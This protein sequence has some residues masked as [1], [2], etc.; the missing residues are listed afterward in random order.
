[1]RFVDGSVVEDLR[2]RVPCRDPAESIDFSFQI[3]AGAA[4]VPLQVAVGDPER[5]ASELVAPHQVA[6]AAG[7]EISHDAW[8]R[9]VAESVEFRKMREVVTHPDRP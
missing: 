2:C 9:V 3:D 4:R 5:E 8:N 1:M 6:P 7:G